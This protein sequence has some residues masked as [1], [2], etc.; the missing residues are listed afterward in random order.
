[1]NSI[2]EY[3]ILALGL[4]LL[5]GVDTAVVLRTSLVVSKRAGFVISAGII[6]GLFV[7]G[8]AA[9]LG[10]AV[11]F[12]PG[13][14]GLAILEIIGVMYLLFLAFDILRKPAE[15]HSDTAIA[16]GN[17]FSKGFA[18]NLFN[19][20]AAVFYLTVMPQFLPADFNPIAGGLMLAGIHAIWGILWLTVLVLAAA[21]L[22]PFFSNPR[23]LRRLDIAI[24]A[25]LVLFAIRLALS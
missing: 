17:Y 12:A 7:W 9:G 14:T 25:I 8:P 15:S 10:A 22:K 16:K 13:S 21:K 23:Y 1:M 19:P 4:T 5:P 6:S 20:K 2:V 24:A 18:N 3:A 11:L